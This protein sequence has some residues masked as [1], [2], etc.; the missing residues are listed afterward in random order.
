MGYGGKSEALGGRDHTSYGAN[1]GKILGLP[2]LRLGPRES[3][4]LEVRV[5]LDWQSV[6][7]IHAFVFNVR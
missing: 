5:V 6:L 2:Q 3:P 1:E 4:A 7:K